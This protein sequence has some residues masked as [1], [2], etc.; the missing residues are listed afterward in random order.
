MSSE[1]NKLRRAAAD[2]GQ[3]TF[4]EGKPCKHGHLSLR[5][6]SNGGCI[7]CQNKTY[8]AKMNPWTNLLAPYNNPNLWMPASLPKEWRVF[9]RVEVQ[10]FIFEFTRKYVAPHYSPSQQA[11]LAEA[12]EEIENRLKYATAESPTNTD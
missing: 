10:K 8:C 7:Q 9:L 3:I 5:Y 11:E 6:V 2:K 4:D 12:L 1:R